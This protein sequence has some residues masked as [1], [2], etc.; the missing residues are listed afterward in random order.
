MGTNPRYPVL[1][2]E[3]ELTLDE[4]NRLL[5]PSEI[6]KAIGP[7]YGEAFYLVMGLNRVPWL[8]S[9]KYYEDLVM[10][11]PTDM[12]PGE[13]SLAF[14]QM[15]FGM[16]SKLAWDK[17]GRVLVPERTLKRASLD[18][19]VTLVGVRNHLE[20]WGRTAWEARREELERR[21]T[22]VFARAR[23]AQQMPPTHQPAASTAL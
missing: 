22:E 9:E 10:Q 4:K 20:L 8:Y 13:D 18:K 7:E 1:I 5:I 23:L 14:D 6:R 2:G 17:A 11:V 3:H 12:I 16:A 21:A 15:V 19:D